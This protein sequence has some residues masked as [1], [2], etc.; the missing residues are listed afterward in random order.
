M[1]NGKQLFCSPRKIPKILS[2][3]SSPST[4]HLKCLKERQYQSMTPL[5]STTGKCRYGYPQVTVNSPVHLEKKMASSGMIRLT[6]PHLVKE[7]DH[8]ERDG[9]VAKFNEEVAP[10]T[11]AIEDFLEAHQIWNEIR[12]E[13]MSVEE[14]EFIQQRFGEKAES[15]LSTGFLGIQMGKSDFHHV[16]DL[17]SFL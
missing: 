9:G 16:S 7:I 8:L 13:T 3:H 1:R 5:V 15:F 11:H 17:I 14:V 12:Q 6:C 2:D 4:H 10:T